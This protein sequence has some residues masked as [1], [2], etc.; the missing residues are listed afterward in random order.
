MTN[1]LKYLAIPAVALTI[2]SVA[3]TQSHATNSTVIIQHDTTLYASPSVK[4]KKIQ[5]L[6]KNQRLLLVTYGKKWSTVKIGQRRG[7]VTTSQLNLTNYKKNLQKKLTQE[8]NKL[9]KLS[10]EMNT[11]LNKGLYS[12]A[13]KTKSQLQKSLNSYTK[14]VKTTAIL[15]EKEKK[16]RLANYHTKFLAD[17]K[18]TAEINLYFKHMSTEKK[19]ITTKSA[20]DFAT[21]VSLLK[22]EQLKMIA[23]LNKTTTVSLSET[24]KKKLSDEI[25]M[26]E[27]TWHNTTKTKTTRYKTQIQ[28][29]IKPLYAKYVMAINEGTIS[30]ILTARAHVVQ[31]LPT[32]LKFQSDEQL[33]NAQKQQLN[34]LI[35]PVINQVEALAKESDLNQQIAIF[36]KSLQNM[37]Y[38]VASKNLTDIRLALDQG[39]IYRKNNTNYAL[40]TTVTNALEQLYTHYNLYYYKEIPVDHSTVLDY[41]SASLTVSPLGFTANKTE[42]KSGYIAFK[43]KHN[44]KKLHYSYL[45]YTVNITEQAVKEFAANP[46]INQKVYT[47]GA[48]SNSSDYD[49]FPEAL[50]YITKYSSEKLPLT[51]ASSINASTNIMRKFDDNEKYVIFKLPLI[52]GVYY[53]NIRLTVE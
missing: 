46:T 35:T 33:S 38:A 15:T 32:A 48:N 50:K 23:R 42:D 7:Y 13:Q 41:Y 11:L 36:K 20:N 5:Q 28:D 21:K 3:P 34:A 44:D 25:M 30:T 4:S 16:K 26:I 1:Y 12:Q 22:K 10:Q 51:I 37:D 29:N 45:R 2:F 31:A 53:S 19:N 17:M 18:K 6:S 8:E 39:I 40:P 14:H 49:H 47:Y 43:V 27:K 9:T 52:K 24:L